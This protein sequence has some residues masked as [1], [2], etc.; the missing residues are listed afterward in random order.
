M[1]GVVRRRVVAAGLTVACVLWSGPGPFPLGATAAGAFCPLEGFACPGDF[2]ATAVSGAALKGY[3]DLSSGLLIT[4]GR[5]FP[6]RVIDDGVCWTH[7]Q[8]QLYLH[9]TFRNTSR[10]T[11]TY[12]VLGLT[13]KDA[14]GRSY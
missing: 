1:V 12:T 2:R 10:R 5:A 6:G 7:P 14:S 8:W 13:V 3:L 4:I 11:L 9:V